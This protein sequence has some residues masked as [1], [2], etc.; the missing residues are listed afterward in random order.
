MPFVVAQKETQALRSVILTFLCLLNHSL[1]FTLSIAGG[2]KPGPFF[3]SRRGRAG[4]PWPFLSVL[5]Q[6][7]KALQPEQFAPQS[8]AGGDACLSC[9]I[10]GGPG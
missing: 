2:N 6:K 7:G 3:F 5:F 8:H 4:F 1:F 10:T 9:F